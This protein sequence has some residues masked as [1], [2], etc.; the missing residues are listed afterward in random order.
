MAES[1]PNRWK[2]LGEKKTLLITS[3]F[4]F[5]HCVFKRLV[6]QT[7]KKPGLVWERVN[8]FLKPQISDTSKLKEFADDNLKFEKNGRSSLNGLKTLWE[9]EKLLITSNFS[10]SHS[11]FKRLV[12][13]TRKNQDWYC[14]RKGLTAISRKQ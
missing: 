2:T 5:S 13:Q 1:C 10:F 3:N 8:T 12:L 6:Q 14:L 7:R 11:D 9:K 4:S